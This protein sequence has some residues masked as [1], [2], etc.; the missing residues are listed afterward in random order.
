MVELIEMED[1]DDAN[2]DA[3]IELKRNPSPNHGA[4]TPVPHIRTFPPQQTIRYFQQD[5]RHASA[6]L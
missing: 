5:H 1:F 2:D 4:P 3:S 6:S